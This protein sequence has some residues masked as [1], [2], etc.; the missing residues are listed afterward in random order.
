MNKERGF[1][2]LIV[3]FVKWKKFLISLTLLSGILVYLSIYFFVQEQY[4]SQ[5]LII[6]SQDQGMSGLTGMLGELQGLPFGLSGANSDINL[7]TNIIYSRTM[8]DEIIKTFNLVEVYGLDTNNV[9]YMEYARERLAGNIEAEENDY[10]GYVIKVRS[11]SPQLSA[12]ITNYIVK[13]LNEKLVELN[14]KKS[15]DNREF[16][17]NRLEEIKLRL[18]NSEDS[19]KLFQEQTGVFLADEQVKGTLELLTQLET[20]LLI[21]KTEL[22]IYKKIF[23]SNSPQVKNAQ[24]KVEEYSRQLEAL[25]E[26]EL[27]D[28]NDPLISMAKIPTYSLEYYRLRRNVE[29]NTRILQFILPLYEQAKLEEQKKI[30]VLRVIDYGIPAKKKSFPPR[31]LLT[32]IITMGIFFLLFIYAVIMESEEIQNSEKFQYIKENIFRWNPR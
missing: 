15:R 3:I 22:A 11:P 14:V 5:A 21:L 13:R 27:G 4:D 28:S 16:L 30:P 29:V 8:L 17:E 32:L 9:R 7:F 18:K 1:L 23:A 24:I 2:D 20:K 31:T 6:P 12:D 25:K 19:L 26:N 10:M